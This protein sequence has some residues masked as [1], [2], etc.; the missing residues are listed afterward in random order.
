[1]LN[2]GVF[3]RKRHELDSP[4]LGGHLP[5]QTLTSSQEKPTGSDW[6]SSLLREKTFIVSLGVRGL[7]AL[8]TINGSNMI[9]A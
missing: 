1:H 2:P 7:S 9:S 8:F 5:H 4:K 6:P 3:K